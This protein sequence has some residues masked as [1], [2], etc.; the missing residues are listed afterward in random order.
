ME[1]IRL[2]RSRILLSKDIKKLEEDSCGLGVAGG[3]QS[4]LFVS[5]PGHEH[6]T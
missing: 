1:D 2:Y 5:A 3:A 4:R 6:L